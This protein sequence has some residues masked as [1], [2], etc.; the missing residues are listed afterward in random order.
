MTVHKPEPIVIVFP[1]MI[2]FTVWQR[3]WSGPAFATVGFN[4][5]V[6]VTLL[7]EVGQELLLVM[8][9]LKVF[10]PGD[11]PVTEVVDEFAFPNIPVPEATVHVPVP[12]TGLLPASVALDPHN[13][14][15]GPAFEGVGG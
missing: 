2:G 6:I 9:H 4:T 8:V 14:W 12:T 11:S 1:A 3:V 13:T 5:E 7:D 10:G 15:L